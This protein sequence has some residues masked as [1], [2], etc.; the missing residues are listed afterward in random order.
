MTPPDAGSSRA[1]G[2]TDR[3]HRGTRDPR[4]E[5][6]NRRTLLAAVA[7][8]DR[9]ARESLLQAHLHLVLEAARER[10][11]GGAASLSSADLFQ[12]GT[13]GLLAA[14]D[15]YAT[16]GE[17][18][19]EAYARTRIASEMDAAQAAEAD[20]REQSRELVAAAEAY[21]R[22]EARFRQEQGRAPRRDEVARLL[23]W[24]EAKAGEV[25]D[26]VAN[27]RRR[28]DEDLLAYLDPEDVSAEEL[29]RLLEE[30]AEQGADGEG[31]GR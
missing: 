20:A 19:F 8:G 1:R 24:P 12:E 28:H 26:M 27:A 10:A 9:A 16:A 31:R 21:E 25:A 5:P 18:E 15:A 13:I 3:A 7:R 23:G 2:T 4:P 29:Q 6:A 17:G 22:A 30:R 14:I 11:H